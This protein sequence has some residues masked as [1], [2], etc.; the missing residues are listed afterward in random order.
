MLHLITKVKVILSSISN[1]LLF[2][3]MNHTLISS[4]SEFNVFKRYVLFEKFLIS[5]QTVYLEETYTVLL[6]LVDNH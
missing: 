6:N 2:C 5:Y 3:P 4:C 1:G